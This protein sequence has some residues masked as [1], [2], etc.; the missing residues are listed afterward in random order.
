MPPANRRIDVME[1]DQ[2][3][4]SKM[5][6]GDTPQTLR[7]KPDEWGLGHGY[8]SLAR[9]RDDNAAAEAERARVMADVLSVREKLIAVRNFIA[10]GEPSHADRHAADAL[11]KIAALMPAEIA[12][13]EAALQGEIEAL[14]H[15]KGEGE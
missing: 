7:V 2:T 12:A 13:H 11:A 10:L 14:S 15:H 1:V 6:Y 4:R 3:R 9:A 8:L 5:V